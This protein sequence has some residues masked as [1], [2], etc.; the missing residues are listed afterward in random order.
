L[1]WNLVSLPLEVEDAYYNIIYPGAIN[2]TLY[3]Y[4][5]EYSSEIELIPGEGYWLKFPDNGSTVVTGAPINEL[6]INLSEGWNLISGTSQVST[7]VDSSGIIIAGLIYGYDGGFGLYDGYYTVT[8][9]LPG[10][11][12]WVRAFEDG[13]ITIISTGN[14]TSVSE[15]SDLK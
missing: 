2:G 9:L 12:Y 14:T 7:I 1:G 15:S 4:N 13:E 6:V 10:R 8:E 3:S 11:A 5:G